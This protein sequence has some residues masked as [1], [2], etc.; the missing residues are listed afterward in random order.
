MTAENALVYIW[1]YTYCIEIRVEI[2][3]NQQLPTRV[4]A[5]ILKREILGESILFRDAILSHKQKTNE[6]KL[7]CDISNHKPNL[8]AVQI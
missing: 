7:Q 6:H 5:E 4:P 1:A 3:K 8:I 2:P